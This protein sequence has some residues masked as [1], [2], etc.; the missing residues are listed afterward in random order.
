MKTKAWMGIAMAL[1]L[2]VGCS[3]G[4]TTPMGTDAGTDAGGDIDAGSDVDSGTAVDSGGVDSGSGTD[5]GSD[6]D[7][8]TPTGGLVINEISAAG[9]DWIELKNIGGTALDV[10]GWI[11]TQ[12]DDMGMPEPER[13]AAFPAGFTIAPGGYFVIV[14]DQDAPLVGIQ[15]DCVVEGVSECL[16]SEFG[17]SVGGGDTLVVLDGSGTEVHRA[18]YPG[19]SVTAGQT[20][21][22]V[23]DGTGD[24]VVGVPTPVAANATE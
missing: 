24:F 1:A 23:P 15:T 3:E 9:D 16:I 5:A 22:R 10:A 19:G 8:G 12:L 18:V 11:V 14:T 4:E 7:S 21:S 2:G 17:I 20:W 6:T 13:A